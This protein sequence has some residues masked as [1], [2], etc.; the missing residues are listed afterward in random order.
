M[1]SDR[2]GR[3]ARSRSLTSTSTVARSDGFLNAEIDGEVVALNIERGVCYALNHVASRIW[4]LIVQ[5]I[6]I[7]ELCTALVTK[8]AV[9]Q[10]TCERQVVDLLEELRAEGVIT[11]SEDE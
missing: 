1:L 11:S 10:A 8:Y 6:R 4:A 2:V 5:P 7:G 3:S 9:D